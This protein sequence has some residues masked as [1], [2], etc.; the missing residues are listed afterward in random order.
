[1][2]RKF[3][4]RKA[5]MAKTSLHKSRLYSRYG[6]EIYMCAKKSGT[7]PDTNT[8]LKRWI[9]K[10][11]KENVP[12]DVINRNIKKAEQG[13]GEDYSPIRYEGFGPGGIG[14][15][16]DTLTD[17]VKRTVSEVRNCFTKIH[18]KLGVSGSV[19][20]GYRHLSYVSVKGLNEEEV[21][22]ILLENDIDVYE[23]E[24]EDGIIE[25]EADGYDE[26][27]IVTVLE[28]AGATIEDSESGW[29]P[30]DFID[31][32]EE[33]SKLLDKFLTMVNDLDD[34]QKVYHN[35]RVKE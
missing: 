15:I 1:M 10:A 3:E 23:I 31:L 4:V 22:D 18:C 33:Q 11:R 2:G 32:N 26:Q 21:L 29:Y 5:A 8:E 9:E 6:K 34:V 14:I 13:T 35:G 25:I 28:N 30:L 16:V 19:E 27:K 20:H 7:N 17:N 24:E 12:V